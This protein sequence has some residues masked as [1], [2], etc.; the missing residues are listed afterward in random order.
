[1]YFF[2]FFSCV[3]V[4]SFEI[5][6]TKHADQQLHGYWLSQVVHIVEA[7][8]DDLDMRFQLK[9]KGIAGNQLLNN[10]TGT[11]S[12]HNDTLTARKQDQRIGRGTGNEGKRKK[13]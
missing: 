1:M 10:P 7:L 4:L 12:S 9:V 3:L 8:Q 2:I 13:K 6:Q 11:P 5:F